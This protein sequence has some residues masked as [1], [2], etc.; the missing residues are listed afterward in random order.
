MKRQHCFHLFLLLGAGFAVHAEEKLLAEVQVVATADEVADRREAATQKV[1]IGSKD[2]ENMGALT[3]SDVMSKLPGVEAGAPG[4]DGSMAMRSRG[5]TRDSVQIF[6]D[7]ERVAGNARMAQAM[8]GRLPSSELDRVEIVRGASAE[9]GGS[10]PVSVNLVFKKARARDSTALKAAVGMRNDEPNAQFSLSK[11]GGDAGFSWMLPLT[12]NHHAM[13]SARTVGRQDNA[14]LSQSDRESGK[15]TINEFVFSPRAVWKSGSD[16]LSIAPSLFRAF[17]HR[18]NDMQREDFSAPAYSMRHDDE[19]NRTAFNR[20]R[21]DGEIVRDGSK[22][23]G[24]LAWS[25]GERNADI[26][27]N[28]LT[29]GVNTSSSEQT[30]RKEYDFGGALRLDR[31]VGKHLLAIA[32]EESEHRRTDTLDGSLASESHRGRDRQWSLWIQDEWS[33]ASAATL[34]T[35]LRGEAI[36]YAA[37]GVEQSYRR[38]LPS[39]A[40]RWEPLQRWVMRTSLGTGIKAPKLDELLNQPVFSVGSNT[41]LEADRRGNPDLK[42]EESINFEAVLEHYLP[43]DIGVAGINFYAR[44]TDNFIERR[45]RQEGGRW[46]ERP[47]NEGSAEHWGVELDA[48]L[49]TDTLGWRGA[50]FRTHLTVPRSRVDDQR[51]GITRSARETPRYQWSAG[52]DQTLSQL[53][54]GASVQYFSRVLTDVPAEQKYVTR[55]R[56]MLDAYVL[57]RLTPTLNL[58]LSAQNLLKTDTR[59]HQEAYSGSSL[60]TLVPEDRGIRTVMLALEGKW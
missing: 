14:G 11:G 46:V 31:A 37:D 52:Y 10:A 4:A 7:G 55:D 6:I 58:R 34:T 43:N 16:N 29:G 60:W 53:S 38:L 22:Y 18:V 56:T 40:L 23:S 51:L 45:V 30:R 57:R 5:I 42:A 59:R 27:R 21:A 54:F 33:P 32:I 50:T 26:S 1:V 19:S 2:I 39:I 20:L 44:Q 25:E 24:R 15:T 8:V 36:R 28:V 13:P 9:F 35:G 3:V 12:I 41:P 17:G 47:W 49:R 48:K